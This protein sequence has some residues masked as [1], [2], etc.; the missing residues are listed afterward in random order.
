MDL[1]DDPANPYAGPYQDE[2]PGRLGLASVETPDDRTIVF[3]LRAPGAAAVRAGAALQQP[4]PHRGRHRRRLRHR[5]GLLGPVRDHLRRRRDGIQLDRNPQWDA[6]TDDVRT[7]L[8]DRVVVRTGLSGVERDQ[9]LLAGSADVDISGSGAQAP[10]TARLESGDSEELRNRMD[11]VTSGA[12]RLLALPTDVEPFDDGACR[13]AVAAAIDRRAV[14]EA[15]G[16]GGDTVRTSRLWTRALG[17]DRRTPIPF[18]TWTPPAGTW[19]S[20]GSRTVSRRCSP[21]PTRRASVDVA[22]SIAA[23]LAPIG[24]EVEVRPL[25]GTTFYATDVGNPDSV[26]DNG[27]GMV[28]ATSTP[29]FPTAASLLAPLVDGR[30]IRQVGNTN[31]ARLD[32]PAINGLVD[33]AV[34]A[35]TGDEAREEWL[36]VAAAAEQTA[37]YVPLAETRVQLVAGQRLRNGVVMRPY[38]GYDLATAG[39]R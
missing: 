26:A 30:S 21:C 33:A 19:R 29:D 28:L 12:L 18:P 27:Y 10:T 37:A 3:R 36:E 1:L 11:G 23:Q 5:P 31:Y 9:A 6:A 24:I 38:T 13:A 4:G 15:L 14:Q 32:D 16:V 17:G 8:S 25:D 22:E 35:G 39:V 20:A 7:A 34:A 2:T